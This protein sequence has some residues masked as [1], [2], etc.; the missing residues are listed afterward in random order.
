M[1]YRTLIKPLIFQKE[2]E[3][4]HDFAMLWGERTEESSFLKWLANSIYFY[5]NPSLGQTIDGLYFP[6]PIGVA[7]GFDKNARIINALE[8]IGFGFVEV[9]SITAK[10][11]KGNPKPRAFRLPKDKG[12]IN[13]MGL[14]N[15][16]A[17][18]ICHRLQQKQ[19]S[20]PLGVNIAKTHDPD[21][22]GDKAIE[23]YRT[24]FQ[25][26]QKVADYITLN[27]SCPNTT[28]GKTFE[29]ERAL[30][31]LLHALLKDGAHFTQPV[32]VKFSVDLEKKEL[33][34]LVELCM[35]YKVSGF[36]ATNTSTSREN[37]KHSKAELDKIGRGGLSGAPIAKRSNETIR[38]IYEVSKGKKNIIGV[39]GILN[40]NDALEKIKAGADLLQVYTGLVYQGPSLVKD[41][42]R[43]IAHEMD[44][45][46]VGS[47]R[48]LRLSLA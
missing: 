42:N 30:S 43:S 22:L 34:K 31:E 40:G 17:V 19:C 25:Y 35:Q 48:E 1:L 27:V 36:V 46:G 4:A 21:I 18:D 8:S 29:D 3:D 44:K 14:N 16:G 13:R 32:Y 23:D 2:A 11:S 41:L 45:Y 7:A 9:G 6:N 12:L 38:W 37:L 10:P 47:I 15:Q 26:A 33:Q 39:G 20:I 5:E 24:S 28:E